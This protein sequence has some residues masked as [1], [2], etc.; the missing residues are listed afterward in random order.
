MKRE[1]RAQTVLRFVS[2]PLRRRR[3]TERHFCGSRRS[4][5]SFHLTLKNQRMLVRASVLN[6]SAC[7]FIGNKC[8]CFVWVKVKGSYS[9]GI[10]NRERFETADRRSNITERTR[11]DQHFKN[12]FLLSA[13]PLKTRV[14]RAARNLEKQIC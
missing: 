13:R 10:N 7:V 11:S 4:T 14:C 1:S 5:N 12:V 3:E 9:V 6:C 8:L 2:E